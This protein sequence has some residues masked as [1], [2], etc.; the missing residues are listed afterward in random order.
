M[1]LKRSLFIL[2]IHS[3]ANITSQKIHTHAFDI[4]PFFKLSIHKKKRDW[5]RYNNEFRDAADGATT[6]P[7]VHS[8]FCVCP[9]APSFRTRARRDIVW[10][11]VDLSSLLKSRRRVV[12]IYLFLY[13]CLFV[14]D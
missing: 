4:S 10:F 6:A 12:F 14:C 5:N 2:K 7:H 8:P 3:T 11:S 1:S 9:V 13:I